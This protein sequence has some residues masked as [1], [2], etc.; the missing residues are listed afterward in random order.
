MGGVGREEDDTPR[1]GRLNC[2][3]VISFRFSSASSLFCVGTP[4]SLRIA[5]SAL[6]R[7]ET[8]SFTSFFVFALLWYISLGDD[9]LFYARTK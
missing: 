7:S 5:H 1:G 8:G 2:V 3:A 6:W 9:A 4:L